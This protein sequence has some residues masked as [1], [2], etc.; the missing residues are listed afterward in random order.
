[1]DPE[2]GLEPGRRT[3]HD[4]VRLVTTTLAL[5]LVDA[6]IK[7]DEINIDHCGLFLGTHGALLP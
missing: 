3:H 5:L 6:L 4:R 7:L 2:P 1:V